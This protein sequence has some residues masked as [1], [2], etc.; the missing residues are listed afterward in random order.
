MCNEAGLPDHPVYKQDSV[1]YIDE[2]TASDMT[3]VA[4]QC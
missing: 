4:D 3:A 2:Q 1:E